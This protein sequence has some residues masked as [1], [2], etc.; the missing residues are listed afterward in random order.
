MPERGEGFRCALS[1]SA[2]MVMFHVTVIET[3]ADSPDA[4]P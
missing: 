2:A 3:L 1:V 4:I